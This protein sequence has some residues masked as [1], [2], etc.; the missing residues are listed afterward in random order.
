ML[1]T[2]AV[3]LYLLFFFFRDGERIVGLIEQA[4]PMERA[5][6]DGLVDGTGASALGMSGTFR[7][8]QTSYV[9]S[10]A[11]SLLLGAVLVLGA[12]LAVNLT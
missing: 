12:L 11:L 2:I 1:V 10:Y 5:Y 7:R 3:M 4:I 9:R 8:I 6:V